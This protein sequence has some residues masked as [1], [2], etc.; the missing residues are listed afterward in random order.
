MR[1]AVYGLSCAFCWRRQWC[2]CHH[3]RPRPQSTSKHRKSSNQLYINKVDETT[4][5]APRQHTNWVLNA[6]PKRLEALFPALYPTFC[7]YDGGVRIDIVASV[8][9]GTQRERIKKGKKGQSKVKHRWK[10]TKMVQQEER[11]YYRSSIGRRYKMDRAV[12]TT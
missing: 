4:H 7:I 11:W 10:E 5:T 8:P 6:I 9:K 1:T 2:P 3:H 12:Q